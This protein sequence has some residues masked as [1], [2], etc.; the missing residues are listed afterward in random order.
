MWTD[1][2]SSVESRVNSTVLEENAV[3]FSPCRPLYNNSPLPKK[4]IYF[5]TFILLNSTLYRSRGSLPPC[6]PPPF[7]FSHSLLPHFLPFSVRPYLSSPLPYSTLPSPTPPF[8]P[9]GL[10]VPPS[11][12]GVTVTATGGPWE[13]RRSAVKT[14]THTTL[15]HSPWGTSASP[16]TSIQAVGSR[17]FRIKVVIY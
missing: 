17:I 8:R 10:H 13:R 16:S 15:R 14:Q 5:W 6:C 3:Y 4:L 7:C 11:P 2:D 1:N 9:P 12:P